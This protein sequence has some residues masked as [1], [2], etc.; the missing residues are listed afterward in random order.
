MWAGIIWPAGTVGFGFAWYLVLLGVVLW[1]AF[2][3]G[4]RRLRVVGL[5]MVV[6]YGFDCWYLVCYSFYLLRLDFGFVGFLGFV[7]SMF[8]FGVRA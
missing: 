8:G 4:F 5:G 6:V 2:F 3:G 7:F 1:V